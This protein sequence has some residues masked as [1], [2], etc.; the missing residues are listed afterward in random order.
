MARALNSVTVHV[1]PVENQIVGLV[2]GTPDVDPRVLYELHS[3]HQLP[4][5]L[6]ASGLEMHPPGSP[7]LLQL[8]PS[9]PVVARV[10]SDVLHVMNWTYVS[11]VCAN[12]H[13]PYNAICEEF[14]AL[15]AKQDVQFAVDLAVTDQPHL[16]NYWENVASMIYAKAAGGAHVL[17]ALLPDRQLLELLVAMKK[18]GANHTVVLITLSSDKRV[19]AEAEA[20]ASGVIYIRNRVLPSGTFF[21]EFEQSKLHL[22][23]PNP[24]LLKYWN[25]LFKCRG[26]TCQSL[27]LTSKPD[28][29]RERDD[30]VVNIINGVLAVAQGLERV[31][32]Q[33]C[34]GLKQG[35][36]PA[37]S[38]QDVRRLV[39]RAI[40][41][42]EF[43]DINGR[44]VSFVRASGVSQEATIEIVNGHRTPLLGTERS[45]AGTYSLR[46]GLSLNTAKLKA[47]ESNHST[48]IG[49]E[50]IGSKC[51]DCRKASNRP[52]WQP[53]QFMH[54]EPAVKP[55]FLL[56]GLLPFHRQGMKPLSCGPMHS[57]RAFQNLAAVAMTLERVRQNGSLPSSMHI[58]ATLFDSCGRVER[59]Q[60][61]LLSFIT[62]S[63]APS[64]SASVVGAITL[65]GETAHAVS[66]VLSE[67]GIAQFTSAIDGYR[68]DYAA[69]VQ[70]LQVASAAGANKEKTWHSLGGSQIIQTVPSAEDEVRT[71]FDIVRNL[72]WK[73]VVIFYDDSQ[74]GSSDR[75]LFLH[76]IR[77][78]GG[79]VCVGAQIRVNKFGQG[80]VID[81]RSLMEAIASDLPVLSVAVLL[82]D[83]P[84]QVQ[85]V[86]AILEDV[87]LSRRFIVLANHAWGNH[88]DVPFEASS[89]QLAGVLTV[90]ME[91]YPVPGFNQFLAGMTLESHSSVPDDW[92][93]EYFQHHFECHLLGSKVIQRMYP[94]PCTGAEQFELRD[95]EQD[96]YVY[97]TVAAVET[98]VKAL[99]EFLTLYCAAGTNAVQFSDC[100]SNALERFNAVLNDMAKR[101]PYQRHQLGERRAGNRGVVVWN[102]QYYADKAARYERVGSWTTGRLDLDRSQMK[103]YVPYSAVPSVECL[104]GPCLSVCSAQSSQIGARPTLSGKVPAQ[105]PTNFTSTW[106]VVA[107][108]FCV[109]GL[110]SCLACA[111]F[112]IR[113]LP[114]PSPTSI[115]NYFVLAGLALLYITTIFFLIQPSE[116]SCGLR[117]FFLGLSYAVIYS[118]LLVRSVHTW[119][120]ITRGQAQP[121]TSFGSG[122]VRSFD[123]TD[124]TKPP[125]LVFTTMT[126][127]AVQVILLSAWLIFKPPEA[128]ATPLIQIHQTLTLTGVLWRCAP[129]DSFESELVISLI[130]PCVLLFTAFVFSLVV[131]RSSDAPRNS[132]SNTAC[133]A[134]LA[135][136][137]I[138]WTLVATQASYKFRY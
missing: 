22:G 71:L 84:A 36:C 43:A 17:L 3:R 138:I 100:G 137:T 58:G 4:V 34:P 11:A 86:L 68:S 65:D 131:W 32:Q 1:G 41:E 113:Y 106:G 49:M 26:V 88:R 62:D 10:V 80:D 57:N 104:Q 111:S 118:G 90:S 91:T 31:R 53:S 108:V 59:A 6:S 101:E 54:V 135:F 76:Q 64:T 29:L 116:V 14:Q 37:M 126:L 27:S 103:F 75:D 8:S 125:G 51:V 114:K 9:I 136:F 85:H 82:L 127:V 21:Q 30:T 78:H 79:E 24:W 117:R 67:A 5:L 77:Q 56:V 45:L 69:G 115:L 33:L 99:H 28:T 20:A 122:S 70:P 39:E 2:V 40:S 107:V 35:V 66:N 110:L 105:V 12:Q 25:Q 52:Q 128:V 94:K 121:S 93:E 133:C 89:R 134:L 129:T 96:P 123:L 60:Q 55:G 72:A 109:L 38:A 48:L 47:R 87:G 95:I 7:P 15:A 97:H 124:A 132:R 50:S 13:F 42:N 81:L 46:E 61:R 73:H 44:S 112:F 130:L 23:S 63:S 98:Y 18:L 16:V 120:R 92:F 119:R 102:A 19:E 83:S 74:S